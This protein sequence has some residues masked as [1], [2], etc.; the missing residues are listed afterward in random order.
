MKC[1]TPYCRNDARGKRPGSKCST[2]QKR[3]WREANPMRYAYNTLRTNARRRGKVCTLTYEEFEQFAVEVGYLKKKGVKQTC[4]HIDRIDE[5]GGYTRDNIQLLTNRDNVIK[6][7]SHRRL[8]KYYD[9]RQM[10]MHFWHETTIR[11]TDDA[12]DDDCPF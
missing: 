10:V 9:P 1:A 11:R 7:L 6:S 4:Y 8:M 12:P 2:C 5:T 3:A